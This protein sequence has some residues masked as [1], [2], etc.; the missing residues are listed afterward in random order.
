MQSIQRERTARKLKAASI[1]QQFEVEMGLAKP[2][3]V[4]ETPA[5]PTVGPRMPEKQGS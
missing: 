3:A 4:T 1:L 5:T 2:A